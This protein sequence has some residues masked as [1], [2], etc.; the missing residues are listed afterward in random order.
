M[1]Q[2]KQPSPYRMYYYL[3]ALAALLLVMVIAVAVLSPAGAWAG[4]AGLY[5]TLDAA[6]DSQRFPVVP[7]EDDSAI[8]GALLASA[9]GSEAV[10][11]LDELPILEPEQGFQL[12]LEGVDGTLRSLGII[13]PEPGNITY[14]VLSL[15]EGETLDDVAALLMTVEAADGSPFDDQ[16]TGADLLRVDVE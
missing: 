13:L 4:S 6:E 5:N 9:D 7:A 16:P 2:Q 11:R 12:W 1:A 15:A 14:I 8:T 3:A 10:L